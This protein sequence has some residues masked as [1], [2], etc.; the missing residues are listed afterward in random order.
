MYR[1]IKR[2][3][4]D[5]GE[6]IKELNSKHRMPAFFLKSSSLLPSQTTIPRFLHRHTPD[7][8]QR[9]DA[10]WDGMMIN[11]VPEPTEN[12]LWTDTA[13]QSA[14]TEAANKRVRAWQHFFYFKETICS[15]QSTDKLFW[16]NVASVK[17]KAGND[18]PV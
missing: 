13:F 17:M 12:R 7:A 14:S 2:L 15:H 3:A 16:L 8:L 10:C 11:K 18:C 5:H 9:E 4:Q 1:E 6:R